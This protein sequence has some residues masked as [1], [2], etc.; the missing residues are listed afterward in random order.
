MKKILSL[1][2]SIFLSISLVDMSSSSDCADNQNKDLHSVA[3]IFAGR[4]KY[5][6]ILMPYLLKLQNEGKLTE[7]NLWQF[8]NNDD[9]IKYLDS[10]SNI[11]KTSKNFTKYRTITPKIVDNEFKLKIKAHNDAHILINNKYEIVLGGWNNTKSVIRKGI[12][13]TRTLC[14]TKNKNMMIDEKKY[15]EFNIKVRDNRLFVGDALNTPID[16]NEIKSIKIHSGYGSEGYWDY[17]ETQNKNIK[18]FDTEKRV[19]FCNWYEAYKYYLDYNFD[20]FLKIDDD[21]VYMD[22]NRYDEFIDYIVKNKDKNCV[23]PNMV[24]HAVSVFYNNKYGIM[25]GDII[26]DRYANKNH[27]DEVYDYYIDGNIAK[28]VHKYFLDNISSFINNTIPAIS[29]D[30]HKESICMFGILKENYNKIF[31]SDLK[32]KPLQRAN[33]QKFKTSTD[34]FDDEVYVYNCKNNV[35]YPRFVVSHY[36]FGPQMKNGLDESF[37]AQYKELAPSIK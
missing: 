1:I 3:C 31:S 27:P 6:S 24:N 4:E 13:G 15:K 30:N 20:L 21:I 34:K 33:G 19:G 25:P 32:N 11:H 29:L 23:F 9:D 2:L 12:Q 22:L 7:I 14:E 8:T 26:G 35:L 17:E 36:Q 18:L 16:E 10:I 28:N 5:M 37:L